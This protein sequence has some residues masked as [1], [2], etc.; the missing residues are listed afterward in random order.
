MMAGN[1]LIPRRSRTMPADNNRDYMTLI[2]VVTGIFLASVLSFLA[3]FYVHN[4]GVA[5]SAA[6]CI[7]PLPLMPLSFIGLVAIVVQ[8]ARSHR[9]EKMQAW[10][11][12]SAPYAA[13]L[14]LSLVLLNVR[15]GNETVDLLIIP[16][17]VAM[18][19]SIGWMLTTIYRLTISKNAVINEKTLAMLAVVLLGCA[20]WVAAYR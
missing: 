6:L 11:W 3:C 19:S 5:A 14:P 2:G 4:L 18:L 13:A 20:S 9:I 8:G 12:L 1:A 7:L 16:A 10:W 17:L 15:E